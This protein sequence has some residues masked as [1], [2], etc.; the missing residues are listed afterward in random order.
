M[1]YNIIHFTTLK[2]NTYWAILALEILDIFL[3]KQIEELDHIFVRFTF[4]LKV[5]VIAYNLYEWKFG[6]IQI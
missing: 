1:F 4:H 6:H 5:Y 3:S 2:H